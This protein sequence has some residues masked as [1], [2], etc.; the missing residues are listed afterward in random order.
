MKRLVLTGG[1]LLCLACGLGAEEL[2]IRNQLFKGTVQGSGNALMVELEPFAKELNIEFEDQGHTIVVSGFPIAI[3][4]MGSR[5]LVSLRDIVDAAGLRLT[6]NSELGTIDVRGA[7]SGMGASGDWQSYDSESSNLDKPGEGRLKTVLEGPL[8]KVTVPNQLRVITEQEFFKEGDK[9]RVSVRPPQNEQPPETQGLRT[10]FV[11]T[12]KDGFAK[13]SMSLSFVTDIPGD[14]S[15]DTEKPML[16]FTYQTVRSPRAKITQS[17]QS[18]GLAGQKFRMLRYTD[19]SGAGAET[20][21][22]IYLQL[23]PQKRV[24]FVFVL[25]AEKKLFHRVAPQ[26]RLVLKSFRAKK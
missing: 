13:N 26:L 10:A 22:E 2:W 6:R 8:F 7:D 25:S 19:I 18:V 21:N 9:E 16:E 24:A 17:S 11:A 3:E 15:A 1:M 5:R 12:T 14:L 4:Q 20:E 23:N